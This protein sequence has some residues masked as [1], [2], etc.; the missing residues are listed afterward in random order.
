MVH[1]VENELAVTLPPMQIKHK[2]LQFRLLTGLLA[3]CI[4]IGGGY[5]AW[6]K[7]TAPTPQITTLGPTAFGAL[8][9][10]NTS[11][12]RTPA[13]AEK[14]YGLGLTNDAAT[15]G[16][17]KD[18]ISSIYYGGGYS[19]TGSLPTL[20]ATGK[21]YKTATEK[22]SLASLPTPQT[23][24]LSSSDTVSLYGL[25]YLDDEGSLITVSSESVS[26][27]RNA[28][29]QYGIS[30]TE[31]ATAKN[32]VPDAELVSIASTYLAS[33][34]ISLSSFSGGIVDSSWKTY[35]LSAADMPVYIP[36]ELLVTFQM[37]IE[38]KPVYTS[39]GTPYGMTVSVSLITKEVTQ[40]TIPYTTF[41]SSEYALET[42]GDVITK[43]ATEGTNVFFAPLTATSEVLTDDQIKA[44]PSSAPRALADPV[45][46]Y[47]VMTLSSEP[48]GSQ[49]FIPAFAFTITDS[50]SDYTQKVIVPLVPSLYD[51]GPSTIPASG[52]GGSSG[53]EPAILPEKKPY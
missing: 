32:V 52:A 33:K 24:R 1:Y 21:V 29:N 25:S 6:Y 36:T 15:A 31:A 27:L 46:A 43:H 39:Y 50:E 41:V 20:K 3:L 44:T 19:F 49:Y 22:T 48:W 2:L 18:A 28:K 26:I 11:G 53:T 51:T 35:G 42:N 8:V 30:S 17:S 10:T 5:I 47:T 23:G 4:V 37:Q 7:K 34:S 16:G 13:T 14:S 40:A 9:N 38:G 12:S 45:E